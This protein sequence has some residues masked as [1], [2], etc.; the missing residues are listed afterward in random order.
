[1]GQGWGR[2]KRKTMQCGGAPQELTGEFNMS[3]RASGPRPNEASQVHGLLTGGEVRGP[4]G[5]RGQTR[6][7]SGPGS[8]LWELLCVYT[9]HILGCGL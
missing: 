7:I 6:V 1:M 3:T 5:L 4:S 9:L 8:C 2:Q